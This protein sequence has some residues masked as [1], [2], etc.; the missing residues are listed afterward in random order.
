MSPKGSKGRKGATGTK[1]N[2][3]QQQLKS[4][5][6]TTFFCNNIENK[7]IPGIAPAKARNQKVTKHYIS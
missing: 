4:L 7:V 6:F 1:D 2:K 3:V 5:V